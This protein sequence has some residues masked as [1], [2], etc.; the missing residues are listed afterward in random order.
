MHAAGQAVRVSPDR[1]T[2]VSSVSV[3]ELA[4]AFLMTPEEIAC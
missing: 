3:I 4:V 2:R 1:Q